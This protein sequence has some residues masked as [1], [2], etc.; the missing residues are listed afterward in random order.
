[1]STFTEQ[2]QL[3][4]PSGTEIMVLQSSTRM[5]RYR[6]EILDVRILMPA[7]SASMPIPSY[8]R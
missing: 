6:T 3:E 7:A 4:I 1:L 5:L 8:G 2:Q